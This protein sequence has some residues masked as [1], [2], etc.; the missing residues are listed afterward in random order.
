MIS[1]P[2]IP[3]TGRQSTLRADPDPVQLDVLPRGQVEVAV[4]PEGVRLRTAGVLDG[5]LA[6]EPRLR[7]GEPPAGDL[8]PQHKG[9]SALPLRVEPDPLQP[10]RLPLDTQNRGRSFNGIAVEHRL[11]DLERM[12]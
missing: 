1:S 11:L 6:D 5:D 12:P 7:R 4:A 8:H 9:V 2:S 3:E 10:L